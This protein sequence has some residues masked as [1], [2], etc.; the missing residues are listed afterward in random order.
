MA[1][2]LRNDKGSAL[3]YAEMDENFSEVKTLMGKASTSVEEYGATGD[4][5]IDDTVAIQAAIDNLAETGVLQ[6]N[7]KTYCISSTINI[8]RSNIIIRGAGTDTNHDVGSAF[9]ETSTKIKWVGAAGGTM[10]NIY[11]DTGSSGQKINGIVFDSISF[12]CNGAG[13]GLNI[14]SHWGGTFSSL[15]FYNPVIAGIRTGI[16]S[17]GLGEAEDVHRNLFTNISSR[18]DTLAANGG[19]FLLEGDS[20]LGANTSY[21]TFINCHARIK[22]GC[23]FKLMNTDA[24]RFIAC[25]VTRGAGNGNAIEFH[26]SDTAQA[27]VSRHNHFYGFGSGSGIA[28]VAKG[29]DTYTY[30]SYNNIV[31]IDEGNATPAPTLETDATCYYFT[32]ENVQQ[33]T[34]LMQVGIGNNITNTKS[35]RNALGTESAIIRNATSN[36]IAFEDGSGGNAWSVNVDET[37]SNF[38]IV[39]TDGAGDIYLS[40]YG[41][42]RLNTTKQASADAAITG[43]VQVKDGAGNVIK[44]AVID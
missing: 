19:L 18:N 14:Q 8:T 17:G 6:L 24:N 39:A 34:G 33:G 28:I 37:N 27:D 20:T 29:T 35:A 16:V 44:L 12:Y 23:G 7:A 42:V 3:T 36:H 11:P 1:I 10:F 13:Y 40:A 38:R 21:N 22:D 2:T 30:A 43:Y 25:K 31:E 26:G 5:V 9:S 41:Y 15:Y 32:S 4:G